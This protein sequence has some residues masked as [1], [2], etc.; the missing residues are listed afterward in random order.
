MGDS[1][2][3]IALIGPPAGLS[4]REALLRRVRGGEVTVT[5][6]SMEAALGERG[7]SR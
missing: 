6:D 4:V 3:Q 1:A 2:L 7:W 5:A